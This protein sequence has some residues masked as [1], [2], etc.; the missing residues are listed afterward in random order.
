MRCPAGSRFDP[1]VVVPAMA[2]DL[3]CSVVSSATADNSRTLERQHTIRKLGF[4]RVSPVV[5]KWD[6]ARI[7]EIRWPCRLRKWAV[8]WAGLQQ[9]DRTDALTG[10]TCRRGSAARASA[11]DDEHCIARD[12]HD[13]TVPSPSPTHHIAHSQTRGANCRTL[14]ATRERNL[15][16]ASGFFVQP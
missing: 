7:K 13:E 8:I 3:N 2:A 12:V 16:S 5:R 9:H 1:V 4:A 6:G 14:P 11:D 10:E 15:G